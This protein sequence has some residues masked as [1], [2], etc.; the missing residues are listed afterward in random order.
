VDWER[1]PSLQIQFAGLKI[2][3]LNQDAC[4]IDWN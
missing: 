4:P 1:R 2:N 3:F